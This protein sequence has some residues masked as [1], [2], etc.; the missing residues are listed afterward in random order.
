MLI[1]GEFKPF[2]A[3]TLS[4]VHR[5]DGHSAFLY[6]NRLVPCDA[7]SYKPVVLDEELEVLSSELQGALPGQLYEPPRIGF[8]AITVSSGGNP[9][10][11]GMPIPTWA[12]LYSRPRVACTPSRRGGLWNHHLAPVVRPRQPPQQ[13]CPARSCRRSPPPHR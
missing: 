5:G 4:D 7:R 3:Y 1:R 8:G 10:R 9:L 12:C 6:T 11:Y 13:R 2:T